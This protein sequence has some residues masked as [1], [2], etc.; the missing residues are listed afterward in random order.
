M[1][2][3]IED[4]DQMRSWMARMVD[5][6]FPT[7]RIPPEAD[8]VRALD[9]LAKTAPGKARDG[10]GMAI[11]DLVE[12]TSGWPEQQVL[13]MD[14]TL[15]AEG[16]PS[17][18]DV[19]FRCSKAV[20]RVVRRGWIKDQAEYHAVPNAVEQAGVR[21]NQLWVLLTNYEESVPGP[22]RTKVR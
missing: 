16:L 12:I 6:V 18:S 4:Y 2:V 13:A 22:D 20:Q 5:E 10:L 21:E 1:K 8:P 15:T 7:E 19:R 3:R 17:L 11:G 9:L 14:Q